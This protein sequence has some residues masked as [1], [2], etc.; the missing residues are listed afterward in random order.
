E[1]REL[2]R[3]RTQLIRD[4]AAE[5]NRLQK[6]LE[7]ANVKLGD[8]VSDI[9]GVSARKMLQALV[10]GEED[11]RELAALAQGRLKEKIPE[12]ERA[13]TGQFDAHQ[14]FLIGTQLAHLE[15]LESLIARL[16]VEIAA[17]LRPF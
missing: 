6:T 17:R 16:N 9:T 4:R 8:V 12:L 14:R 3:Y 5:V 11:G 7:G 1:L 10:A 15:A 13:L 2:T